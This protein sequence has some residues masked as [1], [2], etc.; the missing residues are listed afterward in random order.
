MKFHIYLYFQRFFALIIFG[1]VY[2]SHR[3]TK[4][5]S[6]D[7]RTNNACM[8]YIIIRTASHRKEQAYYVRK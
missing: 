5:R 4:H 3:K 8:Y 7:H 2:F 1:F 6:N